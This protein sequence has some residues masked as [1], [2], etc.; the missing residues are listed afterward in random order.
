M[1]ATS[2]RGT[3]GNAKPS[4]DGTTATQDAPPQDQKAA[5]VEEDIT[6]KGA[7]EAVRPNE[8]VQPLSADAS[9]VEY[10][11]KATTRRITAEQWKQA[12]VDDQ[13]EVVWDKSND[14]RVDLS[15]LSEKAQTVLGRDPSFA[16][17]AQK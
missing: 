12:K 13:E 10:K 8:P 16:F 5:V 3:S 1:M 4:S 11:G 15:E 2:P 14:F 7:L 9:Y 6:D 17:P